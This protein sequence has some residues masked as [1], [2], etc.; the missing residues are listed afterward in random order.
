MVVHFD[1]LAMMERKPTAFLVSEVYRIVRFRQSGLIKDQPQVE[2][3]CC[4]HMVKPTSFAILASALKALAK[5]IAEA[6]PYK[7]AI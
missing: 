3:I 5:P 6:S 1:T 4:K 2:P 7:I